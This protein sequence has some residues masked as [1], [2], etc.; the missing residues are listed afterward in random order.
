MKRVL[1]EQ[2]LA[3]KYIDKH[4]TKLYK[5]AQIAETID[6]LQ[7]EIDRLEKLLAEKKVK[8]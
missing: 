6:A 8:A 7:A 3:K 1:R 2:A 5:E 4:N